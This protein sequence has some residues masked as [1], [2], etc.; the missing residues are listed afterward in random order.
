LVKAAVLILLQL[1]IQI[2]AKLKLI[3]LL[4]T[5]L[6]LKHILTRKDHFLLKDSIYLIL[7][8]AA[9]IVIGVLTLV[10][11]NYSIQ[12]E[13]AARQTAMFPIM[14]LLIIQERQEF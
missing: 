13:S 5:Y 4:L 14:I 6:H 10:I 11:Q 8:K 2:S 9:Q 12:E 3:Q 7:V 1:L